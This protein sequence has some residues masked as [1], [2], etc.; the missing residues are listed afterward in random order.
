MRKL[1]I[2]NYGI[3]AASFASARQKNRPPW[4]VKCEKQREQKSFRNNYEQRK[5]FHSTDDVGKSSRGKNWGG[6][7]LFLSCCC[8]N[9]CAANTHKWDTIIVS[10]QSSS[11][12]IS[13]QTKQKK[14]ERKSENFPAMWKECD[15][16]LREDYSFKVDELLDFCW[17][18]LRRFHLHLFDYIR[19]FSARSGWARLCE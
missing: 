3:F 4:A 18:F 11:E 14:W 19:E 10:H 5:V 13:R 6:F 15:W 9:I 16:A 2:S 12:T 7:S 1:K 17:G 8:L